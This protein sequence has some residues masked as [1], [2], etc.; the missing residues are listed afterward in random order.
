MATPRP[1]QT[2]VERA[3]AMADRARAMRGRAGAVPWRT[4]I[5]R[6]VWS[7]GEPGRGL[8]RLDRYVELTPSPEIVGEGSLRTRP[9]SA[10]ISREGHVK[11]IGISARYTESDLD[12]LFADVKANEEVFFEVIHDGR[13]GP[14]AERRAYK[15]SGLPE[16][17]VTSAQWTVSLVKMQGDRSRYGNTR[18][19][20]AS[21]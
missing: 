12:I 6:Y 13:E 5:V 7:G 10:G 8:P 2:F 14:N 3:T 4:F 16:R 18:Y 17:D 20:E 1:P 21:P 19:W 9:T 15:P 11:M